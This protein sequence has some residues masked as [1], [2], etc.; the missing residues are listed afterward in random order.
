MRAYDSELALR[1]VGK[2]GW[3]FG[4]EMGRVCGSGGRWILLLDLEAKIYMWE[5]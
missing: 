4:A 3:G 1:Q 5:T 2:G